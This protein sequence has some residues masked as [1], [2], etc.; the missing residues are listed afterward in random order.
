MLLKNKRFNKINLYTIIAVY[1]L[2]L[3]GGI[4]RSMGAGMGCP[5]WPKCFDRYIPPSSEYELPENYEDV[6]SLQRIKKNERLSSVLSSIGLQM[7]ADKVLSD[8]NASKKTFYNT[9]K[10]WVEYLNRLVGVV[11]GLF[12]IGNMLYSFTVKDFWVKFLGV[13]SFVLVL[14]QG[15]IG[16]L[17]VSTNL[18]P[19]FI[20]FHLGLALL[21]V[22]LLLVQRYR[23]LNGGDAFK[24]K[25]LIST[26]LILFSIQIVFGTQVREQIDQIHLLGLLKSEWI[27]NLG[28][29]F[30]IHRSYSILL[31]ILIGYFIFINKHLLQTNKLLFGLGVTV[32]LEIVLGVIMTYLNFP[33]FAQ[34]AHL[35]VGT[36]S[37]GLIFYLFLSTHFKSVSY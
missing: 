14:F 29:L 32:V 17:V 3:V 23:L 9:K 16:S 34:P 36:L 30:Y 5:D 15:W 25:I 19:G 6:Y 26:I 28:T 13:T 2:I 11:I 27:S 10:A 33:A 21:L 35:F 1:F 22:A 37:F 24:G 12:I 31:V 8:P 4:V 20:S 18:L 7:L